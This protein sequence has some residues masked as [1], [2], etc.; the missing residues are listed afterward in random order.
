[1]RF[2]HVGQAGLKLLTPSDPLASAPQSAGIT[3]MY[4]GWLIFVFLVETRFH[5]VGQAGLKLLTPSDP[6]ALA[7]QSARI[8]GVS[9]CASL[10]L[11][12]WR[13]NWISKKLL[14]LLQLVMTQ[15]ELCLVLMTWAWALSYH[16]MFIPDGIWRAG[17]QNY[18][19]LTDIIC[20][21]SSYF[22]ILT[23]FH[24]EACILH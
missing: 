8:I 4:H 12:Y 16:T 17:Y 11:F 18:S 24:Q 9:H 20:I 19:K 14:L 15:P 13:G 3:G 1:M 7:S 21:L 23:F 6:P 22:S 2:Y 5:H 10:I